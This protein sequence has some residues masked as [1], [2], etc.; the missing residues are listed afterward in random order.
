MAQLACDLGTVSELAKLVRM[1]ASPA[2]LRAAGVRLAPPLALALVA[3]TID[4]HWTLGHRFTLAHLDAGSAYLEVLNGARPSV[5]TERPPG[6]VAT[7]VRCS[8]D[9]LL[10]LLA[11]ESGVVATVEGAHRPLEL[12]QGWFADA[13]TA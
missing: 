1:R 12:V 2:H 3:L 10:A 11:G 4:P 5:S 6:A 8:A 13:T 7:T 9:A